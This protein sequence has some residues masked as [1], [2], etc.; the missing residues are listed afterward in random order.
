MPTCARRTRLTPQREEEIY[1]AVLEL[2]REAGYDA[3][4]MDAV[5][6]RTSSSKATLYRQWKGKPELVGVALRHAKPMD[7]SDID[8]GTL[9]GDVLEIVTLLGEAAERDGGIMRA[10]GQACHQ[11][12]DLGRALREVL[13]EPE[14]A[15]LRGVLDRAVDRG[16]LP[17]GT[18]AMEFLPHMLIGAL[19]ARPLME[20][21]HADAE[22]LR[23]YAEAVI[24][25]A[26]RLP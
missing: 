12:P 11:N 25:P 4:T 8:T 9:R 22:F 14:I 13:I 15:A 20:E 21:Q 5:A 24:M 7:T 23:R 19:M 2:L 18:P 1:A 6:A 17:A 16:E 3:M 10:M 26:L